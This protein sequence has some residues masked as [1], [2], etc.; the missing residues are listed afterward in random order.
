MLEKFSANHV[1][2][3][4]THNTNKYDY[5]LTTLEIIDEFGEGFPCAFCIS[6]KVNEDTMKMFFDLLKL[7]FGAPIHTSLFMSDDAPCYYNA[8][9]VEMTEVEHHLICKWHIDRSFRKNLP[10]IPGNSQQKSE[11][12]K[13]IRLL[14]EKPDKDKF[15]SLLQA[16]LK[17]I[18]A[19]WIPRFP[20]LLFLTL[21]E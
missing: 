17:K 11:V 9:K 13:S 19:V 4:S 3:D 10:C 20:F 1:C 16:F 8:W 14:L 2:I 5:Q 7:E 18:V 12:Y 21:R 6:S 15:N